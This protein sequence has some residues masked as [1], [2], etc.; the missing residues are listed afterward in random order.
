MDDR[1]RASARRSFLMTTNRPDLVAVRD[2]L[3]IVHGEAEWWTAVDDAGLRD[4]AENHFD[5]MR[6][7]REDTLRRV[8]R[9][10]RR[11]GA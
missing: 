1:A 4:W 8:E 2:R 3:R 5:H 6:R 11:W 10:G 7:V 9:A